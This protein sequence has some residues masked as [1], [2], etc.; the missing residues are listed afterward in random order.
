MNICGC[1]AWSVG[2]RT[3]MVEARRTRC[4]ASSTYDG[5]TCRDF[6]AF[7]HYKISPNIKW[8]LVWCI[9]YDE[10]LL[11]LVF[12]YLLVC[13]CYIVFRCTL[14][15][16]VVIRRCMYT[17]FENDRVRKSLFVTFFIAFISCKN[18]IAPTGST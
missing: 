3:I 9:V 13:M 5:I 12:G 15:Y 14:V 7:N 1:V 17:Y 11:A 6:N 2:I 10:S 4:F 18:A 16:I 8:F